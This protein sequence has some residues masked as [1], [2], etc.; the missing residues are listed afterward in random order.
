MTAMLP[1]SSTYTRG[2]LAN[3]RALAPFPPA[4]EERA[5]QVFAWFTTRLLALPNE[6]QLQY[7]RPAPSK[8]T[9]CLTLSQQQVA[10]RSPKLSRESSRIISPSGRRSLTSSTLPSQVWVPSSSG[11]LR[12]LPSLTLCISLPRLSFVSAEVGGA[13]RFARLLLIETDLAAA[14]WHLLPGRDVLHRELL[15][16]R[17]A[18]NNQRRPWPNSN[19]T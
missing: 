19:R 4:T 3:Y 16:V 14:A 8:S 2:A 17:R 18:A 6:Q 9:E 15:S 10:Q 12:L 7:A 1:C 13:S 11:S 5:D